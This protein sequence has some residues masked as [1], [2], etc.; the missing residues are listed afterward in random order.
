M[1]FFSNCRQ[2]NKILESV[3]YKYTIN[4]TDINESVIHT[5]PLVVDLC[6]DFN[7]I[8]TESSEWRATKLEA[9]EEAK[10]RVV[11]KDSSIHTL[12]AP[13]YA[14]KEEISKKGNKETSKF[15]AEVVAFRGRY[16]GQYNLIEAIQNSAKIQIESFHNYTA[17]Y[18][19]DNTWINEPFYVGEI[20]MEQPSSSYYKSTKTLNSAIQVKNS[21]DLN[22]IQSNDSLTY[23]LKET[24]K[25]LF[26]KTDSIG[27]FNLLIKDSILT[28]ESLTV[29]KDSTNSQASIKSNNN[30][31]VNTNLENSTY[32]GKI[33]IDEF[34]QNLYAN[35]IIRDSSEKIVKNGKN[36]LDFILHNDD[37]I[38]RWMK[39]NESLKKQ[40][41]MFQRIQE[42]ESS[43]INLKYKA[44]RNEKEDLDWGKI[45]YYLLELEYLN[46]N[47]LLFYS[48]F[49]LLRSK[50]LVEDCYVNAPDSVRRVVRKYMDI[51]E[52]WISEGNIPMQINSKDQLLKS[53]LP[54]RK[55]INAECFAAEIYYRAW[56][57][58]QGKKVD[59]L[60]DTLNF[61]NPL[62][63]L[64]DSVK[65][66]E[67]DSFQQYAIKNDN[68]A[69]FNEKEFPKGSNLDLM[70]RAMNLPDTLKLPI[71]S[72]Y[73]SNSIPNDFDFPTN[74]TYPRGIIY[75]VQ[76]GAFRKKIEPSFYKKFAPVVKEAKGDDV[77]RYT[78]G[79]FPK[80]GSAQIALRQIK[81]F[82]Y[83]DAFIVALKD[84]ARIPLPEKSVRLR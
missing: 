84:G 50:K 15:Q 52:N 56:E 36:Q 28:K 14:V 38:S 83:K 4:E 33:T 27:S 57:I 11:Q 76:V 45:D 13:I 77:Y 78:A 34:S 70:Q 24:E 43:F 61:N 63:T 58:C 26:R 41:V 1:I 71:F 74:I 75:V 9:I 65:W 54:I 68:S 53:G 59:F 17:E 12:I 60:S 73:P 39:E 80:Y 66:K 51:A 46:R 10:F 6:I 69:K 23:K 72:T 18:T 64:N 44:K 55:R 81:Q 25:S 82:G 3:S 48:N 30:T 7:Y 31:D 29:I 37:Y 40:L 79:F 8:V 49:N 47:K 42:N 2:N 21:S 62:N 19:Y 5:T 35:S 16:C 32:D 22:D 67:A 20:Y